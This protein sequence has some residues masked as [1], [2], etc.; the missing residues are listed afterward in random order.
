VAQDVLPPVQEGP[1]APAQS[2]GALP[3]DDLQLQ[4]PRG[5]ALG[6]VGVEEGRDVPGVEEVQVQPSVERERNRRLVVIHLSASTG[7]Y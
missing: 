5:P 6:E 3:V 2:P 1:D 7:V 4:Y